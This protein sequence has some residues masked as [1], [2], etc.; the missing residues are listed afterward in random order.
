MAKHDERVASDDPLLYILDP[1]FS[2]E[3]ILDEDVLL[4]N[5]ANT[6]EADAIELQ[7]QQEAAGLTP[8]SMLEGEDDGHLY[9]RL[10][11]VARGASQASP[12]AGP[13]V[14]R[15]RTERL[16]TVFLQAITMP[17]SAEGGNPLVAVITYGVGAASF[18]KTINLLS[19][20]ALKF[21]LYARRAEVSFYWANGAAA[22]AA[23]VSCAIVP[24]AYAGAD[25]Y[26]WQWGYN[27]ASGGAPVTQADFG[28]LWT[29]PGVLG[30]VHVM[31]NQVVGVGVPL[32]PLLFDLG[33]GLRP[34][35]G[36]APILG[37]RMGAVFNA[38]DD[39][40]YTDEQAPGTVTWGTALTIALST[41][42]DLYN[43]P[44]PANGNQMTADVKVGT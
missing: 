13:S 28:I 26:A 36:T 40:S 32:W 3:P 30:Q 12:T 34:A 19:T 20:N 8:F 44:A 42:P 24:G 25:A 5:A 16:W 22:S 35:N 39:R 23:V 27:T 21:N 1:D 17:S 14:P 10:I 33:T 4:Q 9:G 2:N 11:T 31:I 43:A 29:G 18:Q 37:G 15:E 38:G 6:D 41:T 7:D